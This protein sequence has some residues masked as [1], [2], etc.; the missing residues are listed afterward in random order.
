[1]T[2]RENFAAAIRFETPDRIPRTLPAPYGTDIAWTGMDPTVDGRPDAKAGPVADE[3]GSVW[4]NIGVSGLG[5]VKEPALA[6]WGDFATLTIPDVR[7]D[8]RW[9]GLA[10]ARRQ[11]GDKFLLGG[12]VSIYERV[13][14]L[15]GLE[16]AWMDIYEHPDE[17]CKLIDILVDMNLHAVERY[18]GAG[19]DG[20]FFC[21]DW[22]LQDRLM[23]DPVK[24]REI[25]KPA[26]AR[27]Y[28]AAHDAGMLTL[29]HSCGHIT[30]ILDDLIEAGLDV[31]QMDQ[32]ENMGLERL[33]KE[34][35][36]RLTFWCPVDIQ[37]TMAH[38]SLDEIRAYVRNMIACLARPEGGF[39]AAYYGDPVAAG[40][41][42]EAIQA[43]CEE[44]MKCGAGD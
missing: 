14:F 16:G 39:V 27:I 7:D 23:I 32:Q 4:V 10:D 11:A 31:I 41:S 44:F 5:Q 28:G 43:M 25:W 20:Y 24:F 26:Y 19:C 38:G 3:W 30:A 8:A 13:H 33:G 6:D 42:P 9:G 29:L 36:G 17:L 2:P 12:G 35:G 40:H 34:F 15:R 22:G 37:Q 1:M 18:A 21:D